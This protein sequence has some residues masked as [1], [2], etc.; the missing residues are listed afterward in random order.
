LLVTA[1]RCRSRRGREAGLLREAA[2]LSVVVDRL[3]VNDEVR[4]RL[5]DSIET[6]F[7]EGEGAAFAIEVDETGAVVRTHRFSERFECRN[8]GIPYEIPQPRLFSFQQPVR[9]VSVVPWVRQRHRAGPG[10]CGARPS[11]VPQ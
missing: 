9:R 7:H 11:Q 6:S 1:A 5:I 8:C 10:S 4:A 3:K 2:S